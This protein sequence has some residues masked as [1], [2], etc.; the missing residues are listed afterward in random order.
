MHA[1]AVG[2]QRCNAGREVE[3]NIKLTYHQ[4]RHTKDVPSLLQLT[5]PYLQRKCIIIISFVRPKLSQ[6]RINYYSSAIDT[7]RML[8]PSHKLLL[9]RKVLAVE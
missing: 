3:R 9:H 2:T 7:C 8:P 5:I 4:L 6:A 1:R